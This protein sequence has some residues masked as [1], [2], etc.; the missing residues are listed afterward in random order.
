MKTDVFQILRCFY[1]EIEIKIQ[2]KT[3]QLTL[4]TTISEQYKGQVQGLMGNFDGDPNNDFILPNGTVLQNN[5]TE[6]GRTIF[7]NFGRHCKYGLF[8]NK[9]KI[10]K[11][12][13]MVFYLFNFFF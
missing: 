2:V 6:S 4:S 5:M 1:S 8:K 11:S 3:R 13:I 12:T 9:K 10:S 7:E